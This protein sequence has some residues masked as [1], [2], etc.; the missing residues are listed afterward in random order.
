MAHLLLKLRLGGVGFLRIGLQLRHFH[1][2][3]VRLLDCLAG[4]LL[5]TLAGHLLLFQVLFQRVDTVLNTALLL[6][7][8]V[9]GEWTRG[10]GQ[11]E[12]VK[13]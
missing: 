10:T 13:R 9:T 8:R 6:G 2:E 12:R 5:G 1:G 11:E 4:L 7:E 3:G